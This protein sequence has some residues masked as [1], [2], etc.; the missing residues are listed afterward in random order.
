MRSSNIERRPVAASTTASLPADEQQHA[1][2]T[3]ETLWGITERH[4]GH[5]IA[6]RKV[7]DANRDR[8]PITTGSLLARF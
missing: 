8:V 3:G 6:Y 4:Y 1:V 2:R 7:Y 5:G